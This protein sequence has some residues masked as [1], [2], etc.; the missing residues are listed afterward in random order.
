MVTQGSGLK[1]FFFAIMRHTLMELH[2][3]DGRPYGD[4]ASLSERL[5]IIDTRHDLK[6]MK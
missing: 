3:F 5:E 6:L 1:V 4:L 2:A